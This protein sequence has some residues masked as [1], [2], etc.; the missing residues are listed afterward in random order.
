[1]SEPAG[2]E[3]LRKRVRFPIP[4][5]RWPTRVEAAASRLFSPIRVGAFAARTR[6]W[7]PAMVPWRATEEGF[8]TPGVLRWYGRFA[9]GRPGVLVVEAT[10]IRDVPSGPLLRIGHARFLSG[11]RQL[12][13]TVR[14]RSLGETRLLI[15]II[16]F[17]A[18]RRRPPK[19]AYLRRFLALT[20]RHRAGLALAPEHERVARTGSEP[21]VRE[22]LLALPHE[23]LLAILSPRERED[24]EMGYRERVNDLELPHVRD[25]PRVLP[26]LFAG[27]AARA[28]EA[29]FDGVE[30]H[31]AHAYTMASFLSRTNMRDDGYGGSPENRVRLP[32][33]V[34]AAVRERVG[35][36]FTVGCRYLSD[37]AIA[38][39]SRIEEAQD[40]GERFARAGMDFLSLSKGGKFDDAKQPKVGE[41]VYPYTGPS[42]LECMP[43]V[44]VEGGPLGR[45]L[46]LARAVRERVRAAGFETPI[47]GCGGMNSFELAEAALARGDCDL[48]GAARQSLADPDWWLKMELGRGAEIRRCLYTNYC[49]GLDQ[50]HVEVTCQLWDRV[51]DEPDAEPGEAVRR[52]KDEKRR[53][54]P[55][56]W[57]R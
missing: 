22:A 7:V 12:M 35:K 18:I 32:L 50:K 27:A 28:R 21:E 13:E 26:G 54:E 44:Y 8:V 33:E 25:L 6:T 23:T 15:Q 55:P 56:P 34:F 38:G 52:T 9:E 57:R 41:A 37:E 3:P 49:E 46:P 19:E 29:G 48:V 53:L 30:L 42:G 31:Y 2:N 16:D 20:E 39:G 4:D 43:T 1:M 14:E 10:G 17:L 47:V 5:V 45:N 36:D 11:L 40:Y 51:F 24:L